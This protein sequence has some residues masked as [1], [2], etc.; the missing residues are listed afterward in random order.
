MCLRIFHNTLEPHNNKKIV[1]EPDCNFG[2]SLGLSIQ[3]DLAKFGI[4]FVLI[5]RYVVNDTFSTC[6]FVKLAL[7]II[8][9]ISVSSLSPLSPPS[10]Q[11]LPTI[12]AHKNHIRYHL[13]LSPTTLTA[14]NMRHNS[15]VTNTDTILQRRPRVCA[16][17]FVFC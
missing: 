13:H 1:E 12:L 17:M 11:L 3:L 6:D 7:Q 5:R 15:A 2:A 9:P 8:Q 10:P 4:R 16:R 14:R